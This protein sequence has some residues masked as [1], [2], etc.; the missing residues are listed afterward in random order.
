MQI[1]LIGYNKGEASA[2]PF[3]LGVLYAFPCNLSKLLRARL[4]GR[5]FSLMITGYIVN[6]SVRLILFDQSSLFVF[7]HTHVFWGVPYTEVEGYESTRRVAF[8]SL[9]GSFLI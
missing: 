3:A 4:N 2:S 7:C 9:D 1:Y 6:S 8:L 5:Y